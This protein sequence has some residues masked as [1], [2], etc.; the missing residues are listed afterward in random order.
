MKFKSLDLCWQPARPQVYHIHSCMGTKRMTNHLQSLGVNESP[1]TGKEKRFLDT[2]GY[3][4]L[5][6]LLKKEE[7]DELRNQVGHLVKE[8]GERG[9]HELFDSQHIKHPREEGANRISNLVNKGEV[10]DRLYLHPRL[11]AAVSHVLGPEFR[12][13]SLNYR[14]AKPGK[15]LQKLH[16]D[17]KQA[18]SPG[19][20]KVCNSIWLLDDF[21]R[22]NGATRLVP[23]THLSGKTP[24]EEMEDPWQ[25]HPHEI[26]LEAPAGTAVLFNA[27]LWHGGTVN[28]TGQPRR[29]IHSYFCQRDQPQQTDQKRWIR[30]ETLN[31]IGDPGKWILDV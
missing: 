21:T 29:A 23:R 11:L 30:Q 7:I 12:L 31:R 25:S 16:A 24:D 13:S 1:L 28:R 8:E 26:L 17:W 14:A 10:F 4:P 19:D 27:H 6:P 15:G 5:G 9:G 2:E 20:F 18:V 3:L 22:E